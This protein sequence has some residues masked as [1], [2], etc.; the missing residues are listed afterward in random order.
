MKE[1]KEKVKTIKYKKYF[2]FNIDVLPSF[3]SEHPPATTSPL[4]ER[5][6]QIA[7]LIRCLE[8]GLNGDLDDDDESG[9][10]SCGHDDECVASF[11]IVRRGASSY[12]GSF[13]G[14]AA[15]LFRPSK[16]IP[17][18]RLKIFRMK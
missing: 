2:I 12:R 8:R 14:N 3:V 11:R 15:A 1:R 5:H 10:K 17:K 13:S 18:G 16:A 4:Q 6:A 7:A 9:G